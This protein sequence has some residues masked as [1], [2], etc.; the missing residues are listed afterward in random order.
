M[1]SFV[2]V[3]KVLSSQALRGVIVV[4]LCITQGSGSTG[5]KKNH[6]FFY[7]LLR[8]P[9]ASQRRGSRESCHIGGRTRESCHARENGNSAAAGGGATSPY[10]SDVDGDTEAEDRDTQGDHHD[11][12]TGSSDESLGL[13]WVNYMTSQERIN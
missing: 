10:N 12:E 8:P 9:P 5:T 13:V 4:L 7:S 2:L 6:R 11:S 3:C 1:R